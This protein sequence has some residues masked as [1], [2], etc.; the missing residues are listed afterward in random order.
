MFDPYELED[1]VLKVPMYLQ[2]EIP[3]DWE[4]FGG[5]TQRVHLLDRLE[6][7]DPAWRDIRR[8]LAHRFSL[9]E[10]W[11]VQNPRIYG[12]YNASMTKYRKWFDTEPDVYSWF[13]GTQTQNVSSILW[14][15][16][17]LSRLGEKATS[18]YYS[19]V[20]VYFT[21]STNFADWAVGDSDYYGSRFMFVCDVLVNNIMTVVN[22]NQVAD[23]APALP[24]Y[25]Q[26]VRDRRREGLSVPNSMLYDTT[27]QNGV[28]EYVKFR[29]HEYYPEYLIMYER[30]W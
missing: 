18:W 28:D 8:R 12:R 20:G 6:R 21:E 24:D 19:G 13:H 1:V 10:V 2:S 9:K 27:T 30:K 7:Q 23:G 15:N 22:P 25:K 17:D 11:R 4:V 5:R 16:F 14:N 29:R 26:E 3:D